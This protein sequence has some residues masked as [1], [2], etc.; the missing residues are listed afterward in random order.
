MSTLT[1]TVG[2]RDFGTLNPKHM[3][4][5]LDSISKQPG[6]KQLA[7]KAAVEYL[8]IIYARFLAEDKQDGTPFDS[9]VLDGLGALERKAFDA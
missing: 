4:E 5:H 7:R 1:D 3:A 2:K 9:A 8:K 6:G